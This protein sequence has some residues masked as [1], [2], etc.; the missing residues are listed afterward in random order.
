MVSALGAN[1]KM[2]FAI[3]FAIGA[4][5]SAL[6]GLA[7]APIVAVQ[8]GMGNDVLILALVVIVVG[9]IGSLSGAFVGALFVGMVDTAGRMLLP[10][11]IA[12]VT[13]YML[14]VAVL[15]L[16]PQGLLGRYA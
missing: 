4:A 12:E 9:G 5:L 14:M 7:M 3:V 15:L 16:R 1:I 6:A 2:V 8:L 13:I 11:A 10:S